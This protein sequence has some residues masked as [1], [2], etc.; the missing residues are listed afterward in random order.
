MHLK[1]D[2]NSHAQQLLFSRKLEE[3]VDP[4]IVLHN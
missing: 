3:E 4:Q 2:V 1:S